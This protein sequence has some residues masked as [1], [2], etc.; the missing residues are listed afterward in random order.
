M[1]A[2]TKH[3]CI[4]ANHSNKCTTVCTFTN[5]Y[6]DAK[7]YFLPTIMNNH[8][9][10][11]YLCNTVTALLKTCRLVHLPESHM[12]TTT[13]CKSPPKLLWRPIK[14]LVNC[15]LSRMLGEPLAVKSEMCFILKGEL[16]GKGSVVQLQWEPFRWKYN[17]NGWTVWWMVLQTTLVVVLG[18]FGVYRWIRWLL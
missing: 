3:G 16:C 14:T 9:L 13:T 12:P 17:C 1:D 15:G 7:Q 4:D 10:Y 8:L 6:S 18:M 11:S 5:W 2:N